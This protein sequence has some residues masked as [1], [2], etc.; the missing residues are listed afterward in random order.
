MR[1]NDLSLHLWWTSH[2]HLQNRSAFSLARRSSCASRLIPSHRSVTVFH[3]FHAPL[4]G[5]TTLYVTMFESASNALLRRFA[6]RRAALSASTSGFRL[7]NMKLVG[8]LKSQ[9]KGA[10]MFSEAL[11][12]TMFTTR[13][14]SVCVFRK[15][16]TT[17]TSN[18][19][20]ISSSL[21]KSVPLPMTT[22]PEL[23]SF[24]VPTTGSDEYSG[25]SIGSS[26]SSSSWCFLR[27]LGFSTSPLSFS[28]PPSTMPYAFVCLLSAGA[29]P[30]NLSFPDILPR[31]A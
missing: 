27:F 13:D 24:P 6:S 22:T 10:S 5:T 31:D 15:R 18:V 30:F 14:S 3:V 1:P 8:V 2:P 29:S 4:P 11:P 19:S 12:S 26:S 17:V 16:S 20:P 7:T 28:L 21:L 9:E 25:T 23:V